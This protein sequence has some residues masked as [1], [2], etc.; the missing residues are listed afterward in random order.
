M[1]ALALPDQTGPLTLSC[2]WALSFMYVFHVF[3]VGILGLHVSI[4]PGAIPRI[5]VLIT[6]GWDSTVNWFNW[7]CY[8]ARATRKIPGMEGSSPPLAVTYVVIEIVIVLGWAARAQP[9]REQSLFLVFH[10]KDVG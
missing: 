8:P 3:H 4:I 9:N 5:H 10:D 2:T 1:I 6:D 7:T